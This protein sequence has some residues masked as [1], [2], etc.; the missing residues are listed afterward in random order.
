MKL[1][2]VFGTRPEVIK[3]APV[4]IEARKHE[5]EIELVVCS[6]GQH[7]HMLDQAL[8]VFGITPDVELAVM[9][10]G[11]T[12]AGL[13]ARLIDRLSE[14][15]VQHR[16][17]VVIVQGDTTTALAAA[18]SA[19]YLRIPVAHVEAGLRTGIWDSPFPEEFNRVA[20]SRIAS[21]H[22]APTEH[23]AARLLAEAVDPSKVFVTGNTVVDAIDWMR[24]RWISHKAGTRFPVYFPGKRLVLVTT[25]RRENFGQGLQQICTAIKTLSASH[26]ELGFVFPVHLNPEVRA[27]VFGA[28]EG[29]PN[30]QLIEPVDFEASLHLQSQCALIITDSGGIQEEA[31]S[32]GIPVVVMRE[33]TERGEGLKAGLATLTGTDVNLIVKTADS[34]L[35]QVPNLVSHQGINPYGDGHAA[36]RILAALAGQDQDK[37]N[38]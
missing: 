9:Q 31:P 34:Y 28:L 4:V 27:I 5:E 24:L 23:A 17:D 3:L 13:T 22:F 14:A 21:W 10:D 33:Y 12:L 15:F 11:Q 8:A 35:A 25:H 7:R 30:L 16:P 18:L 6:S 26:P 36:Q 38:G 19:F 1:M 20:I 37:F 29:L 32:F 2:V